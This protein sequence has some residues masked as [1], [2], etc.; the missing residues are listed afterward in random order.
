MSFVRM[1]VKL[2]RRA[3]Y[4]ANP[5]PEPDSQ[6][7]SMSRRGLGRRASLIMREYDLATAIAIRPIT[8]P[9]TCEMGSSIFAA[10][11]QLKFASTTRASFPSMPSTEITNI[12]KFI[13]RGNSYRS[14]PYFTFHSNPGAF[15]LYPSCDCCSLGPPV[16]H[17][18][19]P[20]Y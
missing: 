8:Q 3:V 6:S 9:C 12:E 7:G 20:Q 10:M 16:R 14:C 19:L 4:C 17:Q 18:F 2:F 13:A 15:P 1:W 5:T 11:S